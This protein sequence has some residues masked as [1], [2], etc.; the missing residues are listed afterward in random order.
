[1]FIGWSTYSS[2]ESKSPPNGDK[3]NWLKI[4]KLRFLYASNDALIDVHSDNIQQN[5]R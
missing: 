5:V 1:M 4:G 2:A 3:F